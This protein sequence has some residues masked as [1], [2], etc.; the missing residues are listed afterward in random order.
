MSTSKPEPR[1]V[2]QNMIDFI[3]DEDYAGHDKAVLRRL[4]IASASYKPTPCA[5][6][7]I[8]ITPDLCNKWGNLH[9]G[10]V[11][12]IFDSCTSFPIFLARE[13]GSWETPGVSRTLNVAY[14][15]AVK[16]G[17]E[18]EV[19]AEVVGIGKRLGRCHCAL[20]M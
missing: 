8:I 3:L 2:I 16:E 20:W 4:K 15:V 10:A 6:L 12:T 13:E 14:L 19:E 7:R 5:T 17:E 18:I 9:G 11:A 1:G